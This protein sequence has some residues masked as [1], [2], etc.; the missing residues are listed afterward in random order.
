MLRKT[1]LSGSLSLPPCPR[2]LPPRGLRPCLVTTQGY[3][4]ERPSVLR[5][6]QDSRL[7]ILRGREAW[8]R[9]WSCGPGFHGQFRS[10]RHRFVS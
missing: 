10:R 5:A 6:S 3:Q 2:D 9:R 8:T 4:T 7:H 1:L